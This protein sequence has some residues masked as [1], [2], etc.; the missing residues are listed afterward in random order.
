MTIKMIIGHI[1][2]LDDGTFET[3]ELVDHL[4]G[5][6]LLAFSFASKFNNAEWGRL[7]GFWHDVGKYSKEFQDYI[8]INSGYEENDQKLSK[9]DHTSAGA[10]FAQE[11]L[12]QMWPPIAYC[13]A[14]HHAGLLNYYPELG[15]SGDLHNR[16][17]KLD[18]F[19]N[20]K[21][22][23]P[24]EISQI[25]NLNPP[26][27]KPLPV[28]QMHTWIRMLFSCLV[29]ADY[30]DTERF[31]NPESFA[32]RGKYKS[33]SDLKGLFEN[34]MAMFAKNAPLTNVNQIR[35]NILNQCIEAG[36]KEPGFFSI[37]V[38]TGGGKTLSSMAWALEHAIKYNKS[39][40]VF[41][42]PYT[43][44]ITQTAQVYRDIFGENQVI[45]HHSN[46][47]E[48]ADSKERKLA[49]ENWDAPI[50][51]T[52]NVQLFE[53]LFANKTS[54]CRKLHN[55]T[56]SIIILDEAQM[57]PPEFLRPILSV[58]K[59]LVE[60]FGVSVL[61]STATQP[62]LSGIIG[63]SG[64]NAFMGIADDTVREIV[65]GFVQ[66]ANDLKRV[67]IQMPENTNQPT[68]W[69]EIADEL[70][71]QRQVL[72]VV[73]TRKDCRELY[74][75]MP[76]G[77]IHLSRMMCSAHVM[78]TITKIKKSLK[79]GDPIRVISTQLIEAGVDIDFPVVYRAMAGLDSIA[80]CAGRCNREGK[81]NKE[82]KMGLT[83]VFCTIKGTPPGLMR[84]GADT[85]IE[86]L[87]LHRKGNYLDPKMFQQYFSLFYSRIQDFDK[88]K[89]ASLLWQNAPEMKFQFATAARD[90]RLID[91]K[92]GQSILV[93]YGKGADLIRILKS[94]G[95]EAWLM[96][97]LQQ[98]SV[99]VNAWDFN[100]ICKAGLVEQVH[101]CWVQAYENIYNSK[102]G[103]MSKGE[104]L[105]EIHII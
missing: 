105:E 27:G 78:D 19:E 101:G 75:L 48:E 11:K 16:L 24:E 4:A 58:L 59:G 21:N 2:K 3:Q 49:T 91:D 89:V 5:T 47:D 83:K 90:F 17:S 23:I 35:K 26:T 99:S 54:R 1:K 45:E 88:P 52:T 71:K 29:D 79:I 36:I 87:N 42:I 41:A 64:R 65:P 72:C 43:S 77:T 9:T 10:I 15:I 39:R 66:L 33:V 93:E 14:G 61:F 96:R 74:N 22:I 7:L 97:Q 30:L 60:N 92:G 6:A 28:E 98:Y 55:L 62:S 18:F 84:K 34:Y 70:K 46:I 37:T 40:I 38:P 82:G 25:G 86:L 100:E 73:N 56:N 69:A 76:E 104:W 13:I 95:P 57:L 103:L 81:L 12:P 51:V 67:E 44:I 20:V 32:K 50:V 94:K 85:L 8:R 31:M 53:S 80:Q 63:G 102:A 68:E